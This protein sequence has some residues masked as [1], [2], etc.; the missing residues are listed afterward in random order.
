MPA[1]GHQ[2]LDFDRDPRR[3]QHKIGAPRRDGGVRH[4]FEL[5][6]FLALHERHAARLANF[7]QA[8]RS[9]GAGPGENDADRARPFGPR[10][11]FHESIG[12]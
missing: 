7:L 12:R 2:P 9:V 1:A 6:G 10:Q 8:L 11:G 4:T 5:R 3:R